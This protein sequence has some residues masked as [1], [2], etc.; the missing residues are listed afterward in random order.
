MKQRL[1]RP[2]AAPKR[3]KGVIALYIILR[4]IVIAVLI[5]NLVQKEYEA[6]FTCA[7]TLI[8]F[9]LPALLIVSALL[10]LFQRKENLA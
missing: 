3:S 1:K 8:M 4:L 6:A 10:L 2:E 7:L 9:M 5:S